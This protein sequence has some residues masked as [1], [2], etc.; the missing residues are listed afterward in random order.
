MKNAKTTATL[1]KRTKRTKT[2]SMARSLRMM[3]VIFQKNPLIMMTMR[4]LTMKIP[5]GNRMLKDNNKN[6]RNN[7]LIN[8]I[9][10]SRRKNNRMTLN[11]NLDQ[12]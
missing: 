3:M 4:Q 12:I 2:K 11:R 8:N 5:D 9:L 10:N 7:S 1:M 6:I